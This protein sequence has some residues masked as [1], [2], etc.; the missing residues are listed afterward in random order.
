[1]GFATGHGR[2]SSV[3][4]QLVLAR[5]TRCQSPPLLLW[6]AILRQCW[7]SRDIITTWI[8]S[9]PVGLGDMTT[10]ST[11]TTVEAAPATH[12]SS[13]DG[14]KAPSP[15][16]RVPTHSKS[17]SFGDAEDIELQDRERAGP[18]V[19]A[20]DAAVEDVPFVQTKQQVLLGHI[21]LAALCWCLFMAGWNDGTTGP[22][23]PRIQT[24]YHVGFVIVSMI[25]VSGCIGFMLGAMVNVYLTE[26]IGFGKTIVLG[27]LFQV[28]AYAMQAPG[29]PFPVFVVAYFIN[30]IGI[31]LQ[32]AQANGYTASFKNNAEAKMGILH[33]VY[34]L[35]AM[36]SPLVSTHFSH[37]EHW[38]F[39]YLVSLGVALTNTAVLIA[40]FRL[41]SQDEN[42]AKI[43]HAAGET[44]TSE[45]SA[46][47]QIMRLKELHLLAFFILVYVGVEVTIGGW[48]V[49]YVIDVRHGGRSSGYISSGFFGGLTVGRVALLWVNRLVGER[50]VLF[51]YAILAIALELVVWLV[52]SLI[53]GAVAVS[54]VGV[55]LGPFYPI[56]MNHSGRI[57][58]R[59]LLTGCIGWIAGF[60]QAGSAILP[61]ITGAISQKAGIKSL[62]PLLVSMM[63]LMI[64]LWAL[65]PGHAKR[66]D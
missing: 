33:A 32:D 43:G 54:L 4:P 28:V 20:E 66:P 18:T 10:T 65:V 53:G 17:D 58:P 5:F 51:L 19:A 36:C 63:G 6:W 3:A 22:L 55:L 1:M 48:I 13:V 14:A 16:P 23:L 8:H 57:L 40:V 62:Q 26:R 64:V 34:G 29:P 45:D 42:L 38:S 2:R 60:G 41:K 39:H 49:T 11:S 31:S 9:D 15:R 12:F 50:R 47:R 61:F 24:V 27:S 25:F 44:G 30:G 46:Y 35:G 59:W 56:V 52:P 21:Q 37:V 7:L